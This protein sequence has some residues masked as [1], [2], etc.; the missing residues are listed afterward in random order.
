ML[1]GYM[2]AALLVLVL[3]MIGLERWA[4][5]TVEEGSER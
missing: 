4:V 3:L 5:R 2:V 1:D